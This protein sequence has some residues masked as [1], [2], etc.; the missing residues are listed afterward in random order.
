M[1]II[2]ETMDLMMNLLILHLFGKGPLKV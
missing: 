1:A 2:N